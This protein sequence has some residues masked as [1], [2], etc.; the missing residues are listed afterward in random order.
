VDKYDSV[1]AFEADVDLMINNAIKFNGADSDVGLISAQ[2]RRRMNEL[3]SSWK[4]S[5][6]K[7]RKEEQGQSQSQPVKKAKTG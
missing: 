1:E 5:N 6:N 7:K 2:M 3:M 4:A